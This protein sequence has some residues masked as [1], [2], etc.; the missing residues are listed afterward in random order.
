MGGSPQRGSRDSCYCEETEEEG[1][2]PPPHL[3]GEVQSHKTPK[4]ARARV[5]RREGG[6]VIS[7]VKVQ[8]VIT[9]KV[10]GQEA[11]GIK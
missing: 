2:E 10:R 5:T 6:R 1:P 9:W 3:P 11:M 8:V 4:A 7:G